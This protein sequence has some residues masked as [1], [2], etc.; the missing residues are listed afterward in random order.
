MYVFEASSARTKD[1]VVRLYLQRHDMLPFHRICRR[2]RAPMSSNV[3]VRRI[4]SIEMKRDSYKEVSLR[5]RS[6]LQR[7][8]EGE[9]E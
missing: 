8:M 1:Y 7:A 3:R 2:Q 4:G 5:L 6:M 9:H